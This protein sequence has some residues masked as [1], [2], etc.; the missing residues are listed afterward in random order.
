[1]LRSI[2]TFFQY[3]LGAIERLD[4]VPPY[5]VIR[6]ESPRNSFEAKD[7]P[8]PGLKHRLLERMCL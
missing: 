7:Q 8:L 4:N 6:R 2:E 3:V 1:M 5:G